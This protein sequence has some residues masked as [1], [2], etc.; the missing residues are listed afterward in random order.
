MDMS[1]DGLES[2]AS[3]HGWVGVDARRC[4]CHGIAS[5]HQR[6]SFCVEGLAG[7]SFVVTREPC[8][9]CNGS[10]NEQ[11]STAEEWVGRNR[12]KPQ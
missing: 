5:A 12:H 1:S 11:Q 3:T 6:E 9:P 10:C 4:R 7:A 2:S 8:A